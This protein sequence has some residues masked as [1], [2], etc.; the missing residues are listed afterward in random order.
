MMGKSNRSHSNN[1]PLND[2]SGVLTDNKA[3]AD[4]FLN[5]FC[6]P[7][8]NSTS[9]AQDPVEV[10]CIEGIEMNL[11]NREMDNLNVP[12]TMAE[13]DL[14]LSRKK[15]K[16]SD[17]DKITY[18][19]LSNLST[20]NRVFLLSLLNTMWETGFAGNWQL[21]YPSP[22]LG[23]PQVMS[24]R[25]DPYHLLPWKNNGKNSK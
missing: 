12:L 20:T 14:A 22:N 8:N 5:I 25:T 13:L 6:E 11:V 17:D 15:S 1:C 2:D 21:W 3:K 9:A 4:L 16:A 24:D 23:N 19:M 18:D 7:P 10:E